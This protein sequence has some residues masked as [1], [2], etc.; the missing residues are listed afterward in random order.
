MKNTP[1]RFLK[2]QNSICRRM[3]LGV[4]F[5]C[6]SLGAI[7]C[8]TTSGQGWQVP[9][10]PAPA[11]QVQPRQVFVNRVRLSDETVHVWETL[12][13]TKIAD[14]RY[15]YDNACGA[16]GHEGGP[17]IVFI[18]AGLELGGRLPSNIS[19][20]KTGVYVNGREL[21]VPDLKALIQM[22]GVLKSGRYWLDA[23]GNLGAAGDSAFANLVQISAALHRHQQASRSGGVYGSTTGMGGTVAVDGQGGAMFSGRDPGG[24]AIF[25][26]SGM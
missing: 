5:V 11:C 17:T 19:G 13:Q 4:S 25:W 10:E 9:Y 7:L 12:Y 1:V 26:Y 22:V 21:P 24:E 15:W 2:A 20:G 8:Q 3:L 18:R 16:L 6:G 14:G 23:K